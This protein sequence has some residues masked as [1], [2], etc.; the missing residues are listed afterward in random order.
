MHAD[1]HVCSLNSLNAFI[2]SFYCYHRSECCCGRPRSWH[3]L[4]A[5]CVF[6]TELLA[7]TV[8][9]VICINYEHTALTLYLLHH[10]YI[11]YICKPP[12]VIS[13]TGLSVT[14]VNTDSR[15][16]CFICEKS[17]CGYDLTSFSHQLLTHLSNHT[18]CGD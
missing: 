6:E 12:Y 9:T 4:F 17:D 10:H 14:P 7:L 13:E 2:E 15:L 3:R 16:R 11:K 1:E 5:A 8:C 18:Q